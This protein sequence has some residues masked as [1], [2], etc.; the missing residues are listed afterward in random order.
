MP[1]RILIVHNRYRR[2]GGEDTVVA[3]ETALLRSRGHAVE[4]LLESNDAL[5]Q[6]PGARQALEVVWSRRSIRSIREMIRQFRPDVVHCHNIF[7]RISPAIFWTCR[8]MGVPVVQTL[9]NFRL[10]CANARLSRHGQPCERCLTSF[11]G[12]W[13]ATQHRCFQDSALKSLALTATVGVHRRLGTFSRGV[14][15]FIALCRFARGKHILC[16]LPPE[17]LLVKPNC[18]HPDPGCGEGSGGYSLFAGRLEPDKGLR[19]LL[20]AA[21]RVPIPVWIAGQGPLEAEVRAAERRLPN[22]RYLGA[23]PRDQVL[24]HMKRARLLL[25]PSL[26]YENFP[27]TIAEAFSVG[28]PVIASDQGAAG[29]IVRD[30]VTGRHFA[31]G[32]GSALAAAVQELCDQP[33]QVDRMRAA[34]RAEYES[35]YSGEASYRALL[36]IY[37]SAIAAART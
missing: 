4:L 21:A 5:G 6:R 10:G 19:V 29:E 17:K 32:S 15:F 34:A 23:L 27:M 18:V 26:A 3:T 12:G 9:H 2:P 7:Y 37:R 25:F 1:H 36:E 31:T 11:L 28:L 20:D 16:G 24:A 33:Q 30:G 35:L 13:N 14:Q 22:L 8:R